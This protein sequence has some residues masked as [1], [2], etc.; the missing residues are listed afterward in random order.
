MKWRDAVLTSLKA[1]TQRHATRIIQRQD[2][3]AEELDAIVS[4]TQ[5]QGPTPEMTLNRVLQELRDEGIIEFLTPGRR[6]TSGFHRVT[7]MSGSVEGS[8]MR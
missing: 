7:L 3:I 5:S 1:Y 6:R 2:F 8:V 4:A